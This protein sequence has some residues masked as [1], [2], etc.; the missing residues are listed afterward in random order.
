M[1]EE[2]F[3]WPDLDEN[4]AAA[5]CYTSGTTGNPKS[6][7]YSYRSMF[8]HTMAMS[9]AD[10][11]GLRERDAVFQMVPMFHANGWGLPYAAIMN[12]CRYILSG[13]QLQPVDIASVIQDEHVTFAGGVPTIW[14]TLYAFLQQQK[15]DISSLRLVI[16]GGSALPRQF[17]ENYAQQYGI[18]F[19][20]LWGMTE[21]SPLGTVVSY[22]HHLDALPEDERFAKLARHGMASPGVD[23]RI[24]DEL[25]NELPWDGKTMGELQVR[26]PWVT[27]GYF[28]DEANHIGNPRV[29]SFM[30]GWF[31]TGDVATVDEDGYIQIMDRT[32]DL[33]KSG[34]EWISSVDLENAIMAH[35]KVAEA[36]VIAVPHRSG[37][38]ARWLPLCRSRSSAAP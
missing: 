6:V 19:M 37:M 36:A 31:R 17:V 29:A 2:R 34:G 10:I 21:T 23:L 35:P 20:L 22:R 4:A 8:L 33:V 28:K 13:R 14:M 15:Y 3:A 5:T 18:Q 25:G 16:C 1:P 38:S 11:A 9:L 32:K 27:S 30:D 7:L 24:V 12:G 26:G